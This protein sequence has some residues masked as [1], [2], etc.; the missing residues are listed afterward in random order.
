MGVFIGISFSNLTNLDLI[1][2][3]SNLA[4]SLTNLLI[5]SNQLPID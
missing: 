5:F 2:F 1:S 4:R 3:P